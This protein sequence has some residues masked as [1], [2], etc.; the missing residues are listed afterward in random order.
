MSYSLDD[1]CA[2]TR[3]IL[4]AD[5]DPDGREKIRQKLELLLGDADFCKAY[6]GSE[7]NSGMCQIYDDPSTHFCVLAYN[8]EAARTSPPHD[9]GRSW[10][11]YGQATGFTD[12]TIWE[13]NDQGDLN[14]ESVRS[15][16]LAPA[17]TFA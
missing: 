9:H 15:F 3:T 6:L 12:M 5:D 1:F 17:P 4:A 13:S 2:D 14:L 10:A 7:D 16:R 11:V 8:M